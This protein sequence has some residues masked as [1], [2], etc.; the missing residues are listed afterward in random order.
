MEFGER[1]MKGALVWDKVAQAKYTMTDSY[2]NFEDVVYN[3]KKRIADN[4]RFQLINEYAKWLKKSQED[5]NYSL[6]YTHFIK[7][8]EFKEKEVAK[9]KEIFKFDSKLSFSSPKYEL[10][11]LEKDSILTDKRAYWH[12]NL[13]KDL[14]VAEALNVLSELK[15]KSINEVVK[16]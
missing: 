6:N 12:K 5:A 3:S 7:D 9:F 2:D 16:N 4:E 1:D 15:M 8:S 10:P 11:L 13:S 14:Y